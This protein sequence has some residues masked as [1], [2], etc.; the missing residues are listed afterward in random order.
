METDIQIVDFIGKYA[1]HFKKLNEDWITKYFEIEE[2]D[3]LPLNNPQ[4]YIIDRGGIIKVALL[5][6]EPIGVC[7]LQKL[8]NPKFDFELA[9]MAVSPLAQGHGIGFLLGKSIIKH[10]VS[11]SSKPIYLV[12]NSGLIPAIKLYEKLGFTKIESPDSNYKRGDYHMIRPN[13]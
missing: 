7:A 2:A 10:G 5:N 13:P 11:K 9:K 3:L 8:D 4:E 12:T 6:H 1:P